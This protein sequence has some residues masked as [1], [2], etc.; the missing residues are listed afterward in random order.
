MGSNPIGALKKSPFLFS[1]LLK[2]AHRSFTCCTTGNFWS[3]PRQTLKVNLLVIDLLFSRSIQN[4]ICD[5]LFECLRLCHVSFMITRKVAG[6]S[7]AR[8]VFHLLM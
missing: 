1:L 2:I 7:P 8:V 5:W 3:T 6:S 4:A